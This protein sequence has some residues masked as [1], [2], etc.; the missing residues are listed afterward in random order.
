MDG[1]AQAQGAVEEEGATA[2]GI[3]GVLVGIC[4]VCVCGRFLRRFM[5][6]RGYWPMRGNEFDSMS[7][8]FEMARMRNQP[9]TPAY[10]GYRSYPG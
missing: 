3:V 2:G 1:G 10:S 8:D 7:M 9:M 4:A 5:V 6:E